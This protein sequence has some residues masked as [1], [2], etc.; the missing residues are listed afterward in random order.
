MV[1]QHRRSKL[2]RSKRAGLTY[3][4][5]EL[6]PGLEM[7]PMDTERVVTLNARNEPPA[8]S[9][10]AFKTNCKDPLHIMYNIQA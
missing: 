3:V 8:S 1:Y 7:P 4:M 10:R 2:K 6:G 9:V 5:H